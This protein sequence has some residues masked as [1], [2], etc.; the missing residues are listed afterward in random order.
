MEDSNFALDTLGGNKCRTGSEGDTE[1]QSD[2]DM[3]Y[4]ENFGVLEMKEKVESLRH[5]EVEDISV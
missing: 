2:T 3:I 5:R 4:K 1:L